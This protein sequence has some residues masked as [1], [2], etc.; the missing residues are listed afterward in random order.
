MIALA[1]GDLSY[2][3]LS[4]RVAVI[5]EPGFMAAV[6]AELANLPHMFDTVESYMLPQNPYAWGNYN[7]LILPPSFPDGGMENPL[8]TFA[9]PT[10]ITG[11]KS[12][13][14][15]AAHEMAHSWTGN[16]VTC[17]DWA[18]MWLNEGFTVF[19]ERKASQTLHSQDFVM[20]AAYIGNQSAYDAM[21]DYGY[22]NSYSSLHPN[23]RTDL[24]DNSF[25]V[26]PYEKGY[27]FLFYI[28]SLIGEGNM[29]TLINQYVWKNAYQSIKWE[30]FRAEYESF[31]DGTYG[32]AEAR[33]K[34]SAVDWMSWVYGPG[35]APVWQDFRTASLTES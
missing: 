18:N 22:W 30:V 17:A 15:V 5:T 9:S 10:I 29:K 24:P 28:E 26:I 7:L 11:D 20:N 21:M 33:S 23:I 6:E 16:T 8:L 13:V 34:K 31:V 3:N 1:V 27:Q 14:Y 25:S 35:L 4:S 2:K 19:L 32:A 12:Q